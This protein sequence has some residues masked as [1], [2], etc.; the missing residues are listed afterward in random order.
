MS[1]AVGVHPHDGIDE[2]CHHGHWPGVLPGRRV[3]IGTGLDGITER[4]HL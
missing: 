1:V 3:N 4:H 2:L